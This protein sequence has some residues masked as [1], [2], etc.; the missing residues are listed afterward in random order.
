MKAIYILDNTVT[1][2]DLLQSDDYKLSVRVRIGL[3]VVTIDKE[4]M[5]TIFVKNPWIPNILMQP[6][7]LWREDQRVHP[8]YTLVHDTNRSG[9]S[10]YV[11]HRGT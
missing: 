11:I 8:D 10:G 3:N 4:Y 5:W 2:P 1:S 7:E 9:A 6:K